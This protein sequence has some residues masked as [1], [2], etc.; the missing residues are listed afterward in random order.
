MILTCDRWVLLR[1][2]WS[3]A[4]NLLG[5]NSIPALG[6]FALWEAGPHLSSSHFGGSASAPRQWV[7]GWGET[8]SDC[9]RGRSACMSHTE[10][11]NNDNSVKTLAV[12]RF[13]SI[14]VLQISQISIPWTHPILLSRSSTLSS[15]AALL[16]RPSLWL[17]PLRSGKPLR[18]R[19]IPSAWLP[20]LTNR[21]QSQTRG[22][23]WGGVKLLSFLRAGGN[24]QEWVWQSKNS[25]PVVNQNHR[26]VLVEMDQKTISF[27]P[28][29]VDRDNFHLT[30]L[31]QTPSTLALGAAVPAS[32]DIGGDEIP[33]PFLGMNLMKI[34][35]SKHQERSFEKL[36]SRLWQWLFWQSFDAFIQYS[37]EALLEIS[38]L[39]ENRAFVSGHKEW[40]AKTA[41]RSRVLIQGDKN[42][43][44]K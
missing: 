10:W 25:S 42:F 27:Q 28:P 33:Q 21:Q 6:F 3:T 40:F 35:T 9:T 20:S 32:Q 18:W 44:W 34:I 5:I 38:D 11:L 23:S 43:S 15:P 17:G 8:A 26:M 19:R 36:L 31:S 29:A 4:K 13:P 16:P 30:R 2:D 39:I 37:I 24:T 7:K 14:C 22:W 41:E 12:S 1:Q